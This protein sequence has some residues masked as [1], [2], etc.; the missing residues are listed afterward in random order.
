MPRRAADVASG[1]ITTKHPRLATISVAHVVL[2]CMPIVSALAMACGSA[3]PN[4]DALRACCTSFP[5]V[6]VC[7]AAQ[8]TDDGQCHDLL[9]ELGPACPS[10]SGGPGMDGGVTDGG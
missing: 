8:T 10:G 7:R 2:G 5:Q 4:C 6:A 9:E 1:M 3:S